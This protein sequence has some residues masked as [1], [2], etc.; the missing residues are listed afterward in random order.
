MERYL[1]STQSSF[2]LHVI[3]HTLIAEGKGVTCPSGVT[4]THTHTA[5]G[6]V[7]WVKCLAQGHIGMASGA[8]DRTTSLL[9]Q[10][11]SL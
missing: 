5:L 6:A 8:G 3:I 9:S 7:W 2:T 11:L 4:N 10:S 1:N